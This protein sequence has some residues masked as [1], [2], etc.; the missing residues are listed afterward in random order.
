VCSQEPDFVP[1][2]DPAVVSLFLKS[3]AKGA[4]DKDIKVKA[5]Y[6][7]YIII[8]IHAIIGTGFPHSSV[9]LFLR[10]WLYSFTHHHA[11]DNHRPIPPSPIE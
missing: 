3:V 11:L 9:V 1:E 8:Y 6:V 10:A 4:T 5:Y 7:L 2:C